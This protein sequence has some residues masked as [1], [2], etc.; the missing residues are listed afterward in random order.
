[1]KPEMFA[2]RH[3]AERVLLLVPEA[4]GLSSYDLTPD[5]ADRMA[6]LLRRAANRARTP[7]GTLDGLLKEVS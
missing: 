1:M 6:A 7:H 2:I 4:G 5:D 3:V